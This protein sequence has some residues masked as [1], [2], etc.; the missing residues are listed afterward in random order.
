VFH[1]NRSRSYT[2]SEIALA[3]ETKVGIRGF[4]IET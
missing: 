1:D 4:P 2:S 3:K